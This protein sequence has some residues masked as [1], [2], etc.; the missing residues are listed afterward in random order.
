MPVPL[1]DPDGTVGYTFEY[2]WF[3]TYPSGEEVELETGA[4]N[5][6]NLSAQWARRGA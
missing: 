6:L 1:S 4:T 2:T 3:L 5:T